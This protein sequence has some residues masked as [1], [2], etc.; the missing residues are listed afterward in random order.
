MTFV[1]GHTIRAHNP[2]RKKKESTRI[3]EIYEHNAIAIAEKML[4][5]ALAGNV[6][7]LRHCDDRVHGRARQE[8]DHRLKGKIILSPEEYIVLDREI[9]ELKEAEGKL[10]SE[11]T[12]SDFETTTIE[13]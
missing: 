8:I 5:L 7:C 10:L 12:V 3:K 13:S 2:G 1:K 6:D 9:A 11:T 4:E